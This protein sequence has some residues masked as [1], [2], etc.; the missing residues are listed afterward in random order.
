MRDQMRILLGPN[1]QV[2]VEL[3]SSLA[4]LADANSSRI[5]HPVKG[6][7]VTDFD[8]VVFRRVGTDIERAISIAHYLKARQVPFVDQ[9]LHMPGKGKLAGAFSRAGN[10]LPSPRTFY[11]TS[12]IYTQVFDDKPPL[13]Y[14]FV[15]K[16]DNGRKGRDN[17]LIRTP[18][19]LF[20]QLRKNEH[21]DMVAQEFIPNDGDLRVLVL[22]GA[23][24]LVILRK[25][26]AGTHLNNTSQ[27]GKAE[28]L[29]L[30]TLSRRMHANCILAAELEKLQ[31]AG[32]D[33]IID[34]NTGKH[35][36]LEVNRA[37]QLATGAF[38]NEKLHAYAQ[39]ISGILETRSLDNR[40]PVQTIGRVEDIELPKIGLIV[41]S[42]ID[43]GAKTS[44]IWAS[45]IWFDAN[46]ILHFT[47]FDAGSEYYT[48][49]ELTTETF[50]E[51][52][53]ANSSGHAEKRY[54]VKLLVSL[55]NRRIR[56]SF[57]LADRSA[58]V[59]PILI[60]RN[61][62]RGKFVVDVRLGNPQRQEERQRSKQLKN[63]LR[64]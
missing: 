23:P 26:Q 8:L 35:Y 51:T 38:V 7:D 64:E 29:P 54:V 15:L 19:E 18:K 24:K 52:V 62:L 3:I 30:S 4:F 37:P 41:P 49:D 1:C 20:T 55:R 44:S 39:M 60:G 40:K 63:R 43:T 6:W 31:V 17:Y 25:A 22:N 47:L 46:K 56:A 9:Y 21:L 5:W 36:I 16:A 58:Q 50:A 10:N 45:N 48:G 59:Y 53:V 2:E 34:K 14:P 61:V 27:G 13:S 32:V 42:R 11:G 12:E 57:T 28:L 33:L